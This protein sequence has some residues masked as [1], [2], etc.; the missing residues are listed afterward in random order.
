VTKKKIAWK[1]KN[2]LRKKRMRGHDRDPLT[3]K[4]GGWVGCAKRIL[5]PMGG[6]GSETRKAGVSCLSG[7]VV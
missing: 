7:E 1:K 5:G 3:G 4:K 6:T 2:R